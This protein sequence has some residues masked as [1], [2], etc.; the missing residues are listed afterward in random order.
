MH[1]AALPCEDLLR[2]CVETRTRRGGPGGQHR[3]KVET[4]VV[5][6]D[7]V[8]GISAEASERRS[9]AVNRRVALSRLR[10]A[11]AVSHREP[12]APDGP[13]DLWRSRTRG[14]QLVIAVDHDDYPALVAEAFDRLAALAFDVQA[15]A[16]ALAVSPSQLVKLLRQSPSA[17]TARGRGLAAAGRPPLR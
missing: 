13:S 15:A 5:L 7:P 12:P 8:T 10:L 14:R 6:E 17:W 11:L 16:A 2:R 3:N 4:A 1:P 9:Q